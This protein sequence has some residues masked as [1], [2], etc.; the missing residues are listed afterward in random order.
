MRMIPGHHQL[1]LLGQ[2]KPKAELPFAVAR[3]KERQQI[4]VDAIR[5]ILRGRERAARNYEI[6]ADLNLPSAGI[7]RLCRALGILSRRG[8]LVSTTVYFASDTTRDGKYEGY[9][10]VYS[11]PD[12]PVNW[13]YS[14]DP[15]V[16]P[17]QERNK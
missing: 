5:S 1:P 4:D 14:L 9:F 8:Y 17:R 3:R 11:L 6:F 10:H 7:S 2:R 16:L 13:P 15:T 12:E